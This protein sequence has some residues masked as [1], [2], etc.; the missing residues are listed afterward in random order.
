MRLTAV[1]LLVCGLGSALSRSAQADAP[2]VGPQP[3]RLGV[4]APV[5]EALRAKLAELPVVQLDENTKRLDL[6][7]HLA[8]LDDPGAEMSLAE[9]MGQRQAGGWVMPGTE[10]HAA[11]LGQGWPW[12]DERHAT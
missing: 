1:L 9:A 12:T 10:A 11:W 8:V 6:S 2:Y 7:E 5:S 3:D 4:T